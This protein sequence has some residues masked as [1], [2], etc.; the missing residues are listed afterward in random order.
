M[1]SRS[2]RTVYLDQPVGFPSGRVITSG[3]LLGPGRSRTAVLP[4][5]TISAHFKENNVKITAVSISE[6]TFWHNSSCFCIIIIHS[7]LTMAT[8]V[9]DMDMMYLTSLAVPESIRTVA[10]QNETWLQEQQHSL[11]QGLQRLILENMVQPCVQNP[12]RGHSF[13]KPRT[14]MNIIWVY[15]RALNHL[16]VYVLGYVPIVN[17]LFHVFSW[18]YAWPLHISCYRC[19]LL[20]LHRSSRNRRWCKPLLIWCSGV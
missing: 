1:K 18:L 17:I 3:P 7:I 2:Y 9:Y 11:Q 4:W 13:H 12:F 20:C 14:L 8:V 19:N 5:Q 6:G 16:I 10:L 15:L